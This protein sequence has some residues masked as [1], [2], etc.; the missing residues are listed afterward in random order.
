MSATAV[1]TGKTRSR[2]QPKSKAERTE[3]NQRNAQKSTGPRTAEGKRSSKFNAVTHGLTARTV[4]LPGEDPSRARG[5]RSSSLIDDL[6][7]ARSSVGASPRSNAWPGAPLEVGQGRAFSRGAVA[8]LP[9][10]AARAAR[11]GRRKNRHEAARAGRPS[12]L[13]TGFPAAD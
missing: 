4:L 11:A 6:P 2:S 13:A 9:P 5:A 7:A 12:A 1:M 10:P 3:I 8:E